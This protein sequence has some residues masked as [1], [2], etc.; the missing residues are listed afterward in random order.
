MSVGSSRHLIWSEWWF[1][2][3]FTI[4]A[5]FMIISKYKCLYSSLRICF[6]S[7]SLFTPHRASQYDPVMVKHFQLLLVLW[8]RT[9]EPLRRC[10]DMCVIECLLNDFSWQHISSCGPCTQ[11]YKVFILI[12]SSNCNE[13]VQKQ[14]QQQLL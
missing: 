12:L 11:K 10:W 13:N 5:K 2:W 8:L 3:E 7:F 4:L 1:V 9:N 14:Q 6:L